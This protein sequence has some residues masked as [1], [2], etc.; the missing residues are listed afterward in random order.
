M[1]QEIHN[2]RVFSSLN[3]FAGN[4]M[5]KTQNN[6]L[7]GFAHK[8]HDEHFDGWFTSIENGTA[9]EVALINDPTIYNVVSCKPLTMNW[10]NT[11]YVNDCLVPKNWGDAY[12]IASK[13]LPVEM[14]LHERFKDKIEKYMKTMERNEP[15]GTAFSILLDN[16]K[17]KYHSG[18]IHN[19][20]WT[21][22]NHV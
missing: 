18:K 13:T 7:Y 20:R 1:I 10:K 9:V 2:V 17:I 15:H 11:N 8:L 19:I 3:L 4:N 14:D 16:A 22:N 21:P 5:A 6:A 12:P